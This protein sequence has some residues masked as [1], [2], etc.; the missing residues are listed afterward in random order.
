V[1]LYVGVWEGGSIA[2][3]SYILTDTTN[4][5][6]NLEFHSMNIISLITLIQNDFTSDNSS[7]V[8]KGENYIIPENFDGGSSI[9][10]LKYL[11][12]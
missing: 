12:S 2:S 7:D 6:T 9:G 4:D 8:M 10:N 11:G 1:R 3:I 5:V